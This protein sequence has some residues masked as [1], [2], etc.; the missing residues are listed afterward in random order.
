[1]KEIILRLGNGRLETGFS[2]VNVELRKDAH[3]YWEANASLSAAPELKK[4]YEEWRFLYQASLRYGGQRGVKFAP[5]TVTNFSIQDIQQITHNLTSHLNSWL[6]Q[7]D[8]YH[9][10]QAQ[11]RTELNADDRVIIAVVTDDVLLWQLPWHRWNFFDSYQYCVEFFSK[12]QFKSNRKQQPQRNGRVDILAVWGDAPELDLAKDL[13][14]L[15]Q[16]R[17]AVKSCQPQSALEI[18]DRLAAEQIDIL[19]FG[20]H[21]ETIELDVAAGAQNLGTIYLDKNT[22][23][24]IDKIKKDLKQ[25]VDR[26][27]QI[28]IFNCCSGLG[29][30]AEIADL[31]IP[32]LIVMRSQIPDKLA[33]Q[34]CRDLLLRYSQGYLFTNA[35]QYARDRLKPA[36]DR[37]DEFESWLPMLFHNPNSSHVTWQQLCHSWWSVPTPPAILNTSRWLLKPRN[38]PLTWLAISLLSTGITV[39]LQSLAPVQNLE[40]MAINRLQALQANMMPMEPHVVIVDMSSKNDEKNERVVI[41]GK[42]IAGDAQLQDLSKISAMAIGL[43]IKIANLSSDSFLHKSNV[44]INCAKQPPAISNYLHQIDTSCSSLA[45]AV[46]KKYLQTNKAPNSNPSNVVNP[47]L[48]KYI[49]QIPLS[50]LLSNRAMLASKILIVGTVNEQVESRLKHPSSTL[51][52]AIAAEQ[53]IRAENGQQPF[54]ASLTDPAKTIY[55]FLW[56]GLSCIA[57]AYRRFLFLLPTAILSTSIGVGLCLFVMGHLAPL[58]PISAVVIVSSIFVNLIKLPSNRNNF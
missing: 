1:M 20:G 15:N 19:F 36:T 41:M 5:A 51:I 33:Q 39:G 21:G 22:P 53:I 54:L 43:N 26:G 7:G 24:S 46:A 2:S 17:A 42:A 44:I 37:T 55:I 30:A 10:I 8:F 32:Y 12:P 48:A 40:N 52:H 4:I 3:S 45:A 49:P 31:N 35:F 27:L 6:N 57:I 11:L 9:I 28:A 18:S 58:V 13:A 56:S 38:L 50:Q 25:A 34:F 29:L 14:A 16:P 47:H 23:I